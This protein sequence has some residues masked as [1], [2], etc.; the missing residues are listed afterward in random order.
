MCISG[1]MQN[2][3]FQAG[4]VRTQVN[5]LYAVKTRVWVVARVQV[6]IEY[7]VTNVTLFTLVHLP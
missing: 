1:I 5:K 3:Q 4:L 7:E 2:R 6:L